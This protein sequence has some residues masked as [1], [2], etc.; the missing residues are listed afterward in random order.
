[1]HYRLLGLFSV[2]AVTLTQAASLSAAYASTRSC[3]T[4]QARCEATNMGN[5]GQCQMLYDAALKDGGVFASPAARVA[6]KLPG[7]PSNTCHTD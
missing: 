2:A 6:A 7:G 3:K 5:A 1:M 4:L